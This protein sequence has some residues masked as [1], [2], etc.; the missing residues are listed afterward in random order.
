MSQRV[1]K[2]TSEAGKQMWENV[3]QAAK[4]TPSWVKPRVKA[5][6]AKMVD[7]IATSQRSG[8]EHR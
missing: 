2:N 8:D 5:A 3:R 6:S 7:H 4:G 1:S